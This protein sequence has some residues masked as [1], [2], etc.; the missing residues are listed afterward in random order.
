M[1]GCPANVGRG[2]GFRHA[3]LCLGNPASHSGLPYVNLAI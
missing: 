2:Y 1:S 3:E